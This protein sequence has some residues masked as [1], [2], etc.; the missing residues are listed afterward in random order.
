MENLKTDTL[1]A[2][3]VAGLEPVLAA[4][5]SA[6]NANDVIPINRAVSFSGDMAMLYRANYCCRTALR[7]LKPLF[8]FK[9]AEQK[10][11]YENLHA[12]AWEDVLWPDCTISIDAVIS[13]TVFTNSQFVAQK[14][15]DAIVD[16]I[17]EKS[18]RRPSVSLDNPDFRINVHL[19]RDTCTVSLDSSGQSLHKRGYRRSTG[20]APINEVLASGLIQLSGWDRVQ[21]LIDPMCGSGTL[22][23]EAAML[24]RNTPAGLFREEFGFM[25]WRGFDADLWAEVRASAMA[26]RREDAPLLI[27]MDKLDR[28]IKSAQENCRYSGLSGIVDFQVMPFEESQPPVKEGV[29]ITNPPY[30]ERIKL[31]DSIAFYKM[32]G[33]VLKQKYAGYT[34]WVISSDLDALKFIGLKPSKKITVFNGPLECRFVKFD[35]FAG[36]RGASQ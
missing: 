2:K 25:K 20:Q 10:D 21:P 4:E 9:L 36:K 18:G 28:A 26:L 6:L 15:K 24:A 13:Y 5:L 32:I 30:D 29:I 35:L 33:N 27:G 17:R 11:L 12:F 31:D 8:Q 34:A 1:I 16:R 3:T 14:S 7:I 23:I 19:F 22:L